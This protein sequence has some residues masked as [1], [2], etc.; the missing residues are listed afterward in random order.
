MPEK[1]D[2]WELVLEGRYDE[3]ISRLYEQY[4]EIGA[5]GFLG[6]IGCAYMLK[7]DPDRAVEIMEGLLSRKYAGTTHYALAGVANWLCCGHEQAVSLWKK[8]RSCQYTD[9]AGGMELPLLLF[10]ASV[11]TPVLIG[12]DETKDLLQQQLQ[13]SWAAC[14]P[15]PLGAFVLGK[16]T[17]DEARQKAV[18]TVEEVT[19]RQTMQVEFYAGLRALAGG[20]ARRFN[21]C[22]KRCASTK[23]GELTNEFYLARHEVAHLEAER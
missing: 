12:K 6:N 18:F 15:G 9:A 23:G 10:Y 20:D 11:R 13:H 5:D 22:M 3:A 17:E 19:R 16:M 1:Q 8:G 14:W 7:G 21:A 4:E 2:G